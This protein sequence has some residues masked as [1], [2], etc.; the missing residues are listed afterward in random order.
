[1][2]R[3]YHKLLEVGPNMLADNAIISQA[4]EIQ[5]ANLGH[6]AKDSMN[7]SSSFT[8]FYYISSKRG[9]WPFPV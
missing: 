5:L 1:M 3:T 7:C 4:A 2:V 8:M 9:N 6:D